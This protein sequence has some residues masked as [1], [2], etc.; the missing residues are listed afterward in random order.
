[1][2]HLKLLEKLEQEKSKT[3]RSSKII[4][5][6]PKINKMET[7]KPYKESVKQKTGSLKK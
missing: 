3:S 2:L 7:T 6:M 5:I 1:M 4:T